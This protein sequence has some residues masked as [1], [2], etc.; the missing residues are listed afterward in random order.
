MGDWREGWWRHGQR[1]FQI[2]NRKPTRRAS[3]KTNQIVTPSSI[4]TKGDH[5]GGLLLRS[6]KRLTSYGFFVDPNCGGPKEHTIKAKVELQVEHTIKAK[7][8]HTIMLPVWGSSVLGP[9]TDLVERARCGGEGFPL[10]KNCGKTQNLGL[11]YK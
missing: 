1:A 6:R 9:K 10:K 7:V 4:S 3:I 2:K 11:L 8:E 5:K